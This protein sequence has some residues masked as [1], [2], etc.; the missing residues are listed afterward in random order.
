MI[1]DGEWGFMDLLRN[2]TVEFLD[3]EEEENTLIAMYASDIGSHTTHLEIAPPTILGISAALIPFP[4]R[5]Q[6]PRNVYMAGMAKQSVGVP[7][8]NFK[9]RV[10]TRAHFFHYPQKPLVKTRAMDPIGYEERPAGQNF[11]VA[12][13]S[14][15]GYNIEDALIMNKASIERG[16]GRSTFTRVYESEERKYPGGQEDRFEVPD[17]SVR[18]YRASESYRNLGEDGI[19]ETEVEVQ[20]GDVLIGRTSP[21]RFLEEY[22]EFEIQ[23]PNR[24]ETSVAVRHGESG[25]VDGVILTETIDGNRLVKVKVRDLRIPELGDK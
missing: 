7:A 25:V 5:N 10:D 11:V 9:F 20:G 18:G 17:R 15:E 6:S 3:A 1:K 16:L 19:I 2:G 22:S 14:F 21:P 23:S 4:E 24:R 13:L 12:I 8:S